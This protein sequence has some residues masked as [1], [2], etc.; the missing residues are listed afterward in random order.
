MAA[1]RHEARG[2][3]RE[4]DGGTPGRKLRP[5]SCCLWVSQTGMN[6]SCVKWTASP[7]SNRKHYASF[8]GVKKDMTWKMYLRGVTRGSPLES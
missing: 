8:T 5:S 4:P 7:I 1:I 3:A 6:P 2:V